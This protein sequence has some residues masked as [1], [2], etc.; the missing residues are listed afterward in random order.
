MVQNSLVVIDSCLFQCPLGGPLGNKPKI[1]SA[2]KTM[3]EVVSGLSFFKRL[4]AETIP[5][6]SSILVGHQIRIPFL[7]SHCIPFLRT[8][9]IA[10]GQQN[11]Q[12][13]CNNRTERY[14]L[15]ALHVIDFRQDENQ[16]APDRDG[17]QNLVAGAVERLVLS[18][19]DL[20]TTTGLESATTRQRMDG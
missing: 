9:S 11:F 1:E 3:V 4:A 2:G 16:H 8:G 12:E 5:L 15:V 17:D 20:Q 6:I 10:T 18:S 7:G 19:V 13:T 14:I